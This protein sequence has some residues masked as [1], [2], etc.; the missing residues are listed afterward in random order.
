MVNRAQASAVG[1]DYFVDHY[2]R[3]RRR[4]PAAPVHSRRGIHGVLLRDQHLLVVR[5]PDAD[6]LELPGGGIESGETMAEALTRE[7][8]EETGL[9]LSLD[10]IEWQR[11]TQFRHRYYS[12]K[13][14]AYWDYA[15]HFVLVATPQLP[16]FGAPFEVGNEPM[17][18]DLSR[19]EEHR[20]HH[21]HRAGLDR[22]LTRFQDRP[23]DKRRAD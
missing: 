18:I 20:L 17:W 23:G 12:S 4:P 6:W 19:L 10:A 7:L 11:E 22:L 1:E 8:H 13:N 3:L 16:P 21:S 14:G 9:L 2:G 15:Q 5:P